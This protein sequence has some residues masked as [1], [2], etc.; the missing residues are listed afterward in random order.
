MISYQARKLVDQGLLKPVLEEFERPASPVHLLYLPNGLLPL[1]LRTF[2][3]FAAP[4][5]R[6]ALG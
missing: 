6:A 3:D 5:L 1:K 2:L 4:R